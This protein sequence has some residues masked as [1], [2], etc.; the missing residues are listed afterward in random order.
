MRPLGKTILAAA[1]AIVILSPLAVDAQCSACAGADAA[2]AWDHSPSASRFLSP[3]GLDR[4]GVTA[5]LMPQQTLRPVSL[6]I[7]IVN[8]GPDNRGEIGPNRTV[9]ADSSAANPMPLSDDETDSMP[10]GGNRFYIA[11]SGVSRPF[12]AMEAGAWAGG[13]WGLLL[14]DNRP[15][16][17]A[18]SSDEDPI[19]S[20]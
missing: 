11:G 14:I 3:P 5:E 13:V 17:G 18:A 15:G 6:V 8:V 4:S 16:E 10:V 12:D 2:G 20:D 1:A 7:P 9:M 19:V